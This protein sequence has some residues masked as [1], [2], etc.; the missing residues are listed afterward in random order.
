LIGAT[1]LS[2]IGIATISIQKASAKECNNSHS[3]AN[4]NNAD[5]DS[6]TCT[7]KHDSNDHQHYVTTTKGSIP[8]RLPMPFP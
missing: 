3:K 8:F 6:A 4:N 1:V 2:L 5:A 7:Y